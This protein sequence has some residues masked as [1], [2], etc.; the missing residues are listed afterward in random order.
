L[1]STN[2]QEFSKLG[3][4]NGSRS[5]EA[6]PMLGSSLVPDPQ[7]QDQLDIARVMSVTKITA[8]LREALGSLLL[9]FFYGLF[10]GRAKFCCKSAQ[11]CATHCESGMTNYLA[12]ATICKAV[13]RYAIR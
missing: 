12:S 3:T 13:K 10:Y 9:Q 8:L 2:P 4:L 11:F 1:I 5:G 7:F 6:L